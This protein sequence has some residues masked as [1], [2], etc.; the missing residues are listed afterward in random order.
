MLG[1]R[2]MLKVSLFS[3]GSCFHPECV[4]IQ[5]GALH[6]RKFPATVALFEHPKEGFTLLDTGYSDRFFDETKNFPAKFYRML[7]PVDLKPGEALIDQLKIRG[8]NAGD[9]RRII[10]SHF[11]G[12]HVG[13][14]KD[15]PS[16][17]FIFHRRAFER[18]KKLRG[19]R[20]TKAGY[21]PGLIPAD[22]E[23]RS[24]QFESFDFKFRLPFAE[25]GYGLDLFQDQSLILVE[26]PGHMDGHIGVIANLDSP[27]PQF[28][29]GDA[30]WMDESYKEN[31]SPSWIA[32]LI[33]DDFEES[34]RTLKRIHEF[35]KSQ[36]SFKIIP[37]HSL[38]AFRE[39]SGG[40]S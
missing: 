28:F 2:P 24:Q 17:Q 11:H 4:V 38:E 30:C 23:S 32:S 29:V 18:V 13:G 3:S 21:L 9:I 25:F 7:T 27:S 5:G 20:A 19:W 31:R 37:C 39:F 36:P 10:I 12:D 16:A 33:F 35:S 26:L 40:I 8:I 6:S 1:G 14:L 22:L 34:K 15:F